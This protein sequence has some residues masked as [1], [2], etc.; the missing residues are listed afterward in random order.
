MLWVLRRRYLS[1]TTYGD[2]LAEQFSHSPL[3]ITSDSRRTR[4][5]KEAED[6]EDTL[7]QSRSS[8]TPQRSQM[9]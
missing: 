8:T 4:L 9:K 1:V 6:G 2:H 7:C 5:P 3:K